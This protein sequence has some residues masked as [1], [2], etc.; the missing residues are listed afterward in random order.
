MGVPEAFWIEA[1]YA[2]WV[3]AYRITQQ[4]GRPVVAEMRVFPDEASRARPGEWSTDTAHVPTGGLPARLV[5]GLKPGEDLAVGLKIGNRYVRL[6]P[7][8]ANR[9]RRAG[10][11]RLKKTRPGHGYSDNELLRAAVFYVERGGRRPVADLAVA[12]KLEHQQARDLLQAAGEKGFLTPGTRGK[13]SR[14]LTEKAKAL[15]AK[16][17]SR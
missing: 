4:G 11:R 14:A 3:A 2:G 8:A 1:I 7:P 10:F 6:V 12:W 13:T 5:R 15:L 16:E 17:S 9:F